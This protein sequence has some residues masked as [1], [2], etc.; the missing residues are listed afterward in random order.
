M[1]DG[2]STTPGIVVRGS[3]A[4]YVIRITKVIIIIIIIIIKTYRALYLTL[5]FSALYSAWLRLKT[6][7][8]SYSNAKENRCVFKSFLNPWRTSAARI[9]LRREFQRLGPANTKLRSPQERRQEGGTTNKLA[10]AERSA[11]VG[12]MGISTPSGTLELVHVGL[13]R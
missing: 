4:V 7:A 11:R 3:L 2:G 8:G 5:S 1:V 9:V 6:E 12:L 13:G 10:S